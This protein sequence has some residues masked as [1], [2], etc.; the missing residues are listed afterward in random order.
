MADPN[1]PSGA[2]PGDPRFGLSEAELRDY[3]RTKS[4]A[5]IVRGMLKPDGGIEARAGAMDPHLD[6]LRASRDRIRFAGPL[7]TGE[8]RRRSQ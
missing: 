5:W 2:L 1:N 7:F 8:K 3:Y 6:Y 4:P